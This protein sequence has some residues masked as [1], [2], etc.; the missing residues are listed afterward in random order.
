MVVCCIQMDSQGIDCFLLMGVIQG[1]MGNLW[2]KKGWRICDYLF[3]M[4]EAM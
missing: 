4:G 3:G 1:L 2:G